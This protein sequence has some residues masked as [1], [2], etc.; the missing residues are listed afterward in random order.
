VSEEGSD[1][2]FLQAI[3]VPADETC[4][5]LYEA[6]SP[7]AVREA[8]N[9]A[10]LRCTRITTAFTSETRGHRAPTRQTT[11]QEVVQ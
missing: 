6:S 10:G 4:F 11:S 8:A 7:D 5:Y 2:R 3:L 9:R 1:V